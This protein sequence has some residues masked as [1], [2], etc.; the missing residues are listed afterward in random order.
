MGSTWREGPGCPQSDLA[1]AGIG[2][3]ERP[4][5]P[6]LGA[7]EDSSTARALTVGTAVALAVTLGVAVWAVRSLGGGWSGWPG[8]AGLRDAAARRKWELVSERPG[9]GG[10]GS[11]TWAQPAFLKDHWTGGQSGQPPDQVPWET[12]SLLLLAPGAQAI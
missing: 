2:D 5:G 11:Q 12:V 3:A 10:R 9:L 4:A 8:Q 6:G 7:L 1:R